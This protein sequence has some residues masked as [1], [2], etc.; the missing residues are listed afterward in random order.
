MRMTTALK[1][2]IPTTDLHHSKGGREGLCDGTHQTKSESGFGNGKCVRELQA[3]VAPKTPQGVLV[4]GHAG[5]AINKL[6]VRTMR[7]MTAM[8]DV[9]STTTG[10]PSSP[11]YP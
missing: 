6:S 7:M 2:V 3:L 1:A 8:K 11:V 4:G 10:R 9:I 5:L